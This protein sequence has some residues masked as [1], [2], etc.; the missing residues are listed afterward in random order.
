MT[1]EAL[2][3][4]AF[5]DVEDAEPTMNEGAHFV[6]E[7]LPSPRDP[8]VYYWYY[9]TLAVFQ[10][11]GDD[12]QKWNGAMQDALLNSQ[13]Y[14]SRFAGSWDPDAKWGAY[15]GRVYS[16]ALGALCLEVYY[17]YLPLYGGDAAERFTEL[18]ETPLP[19]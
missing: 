16:T 2:V 13:R 6:L 19:R 10:R 5:L 14:D 9:G 15:G 18:P 3:C 4:R 1:A 17:R 11:Q 8:N 12:W 7:E